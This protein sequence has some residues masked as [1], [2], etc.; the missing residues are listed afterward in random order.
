MYLMLFSWNSGIKVMNLQLTVAVKFLL[1]FC[2]QQN[3]LLLASLRL[4][5]L[6]E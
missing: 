6:N 2:C 3:E 4:A 5:D 1:N